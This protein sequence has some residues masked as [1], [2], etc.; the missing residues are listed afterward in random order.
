MP[1]NLLHDIPAEWMRMLLVVAGTATVHLVA[2]LIL[3]HASR[4]AERTINVWDDALID[5][6]RRPLPVLIWL[7][8]LFIILHLIHQKTGEQ[9]LE[10]VVHIQHISVIGCIAW[11]LLSLIRNVS[12]N[13]VTLRTQN[14]ESF[15]R[16]TLDGISKLLR[17]STLIIAV[18]VSLQTLGFSISGVLAFGGVGGIAVGF[19]AKDLLANFFGGLTI[20]LDRPFH[21]EDFIRLSDPQ[22]EGSV[23]YIGWRHTRIRSPEKTAVYIPNAV[24]TSVVVENLT[25]RSHRRLELTISLRYQDIDKVDAVSADIRAL[26]E[27]HPDIDHNLAVATGLDQLAES[28]LDIKVQAFTT[29]TEL[30]P[31]R[32]LKQS[33][34]L[35]IAGI[36]S[37][38]GAD[39][40]F[41][42]R[43]LHIVPDGAS[44]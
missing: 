29:V 42:T 39:M 28:S 13:M 5:S 36:V 35:Q 24:F 20:H 40:P 30:L 25:R 10:Y 26:L 2:H 32:R 23:E 3:A 38:H 12:E 37:A 15:D 22:I 6:A 11:F 43:T 41:P 16:S 7:T 31:F 4:I 8:G 27:T 9:L 14:G 1:A 21:V 44:A 33:L 34:L 18:L 17:L 19:A